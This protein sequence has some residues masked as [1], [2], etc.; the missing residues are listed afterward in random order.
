M[1]IITLL[2]VCTFMHPIGAPLILESVNEPNIVDFSLMSSRMINLSEDQDLDFNDFKIPWIDKLFLWPCSSL[3]VYIIVLI[4]IRMVFLL[5]GL[6]AYIF[7][8]LFH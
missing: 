6:T 7:G 8:L 5:Y 3:I 1:I 4:A 2:V